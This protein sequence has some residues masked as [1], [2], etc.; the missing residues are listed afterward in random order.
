MKLINI[1]GLGGIHGWMP[2]K[3]ESFKV[4]G[5]RDHTAVA[6]SSVFILPIRIRVISPTV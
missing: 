1:N 3:E 2:T 5:I 4:D 6:F